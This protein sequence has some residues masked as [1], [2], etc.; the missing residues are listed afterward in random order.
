MSRS[1]SFMLPIEIDSDGFPVR[2]RIDEMGLFCGG[3]ISDLGKEEFDRLS[4]LFLSTGDRAFTFYVYDNDLV[5]FGKFSAGK[6]SVHTHCDHYSIFNLIFEDAA[7]GNY[8]FVSNNGQW[9]VFFGKES[10]VVNCMSIIDSPV[11]VEAES[12]FESSFYSDS[13]KAEG[14]RFIEKY[15]NA[16]LGSPPSSP[17]SGSGLVL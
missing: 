11:L 13:E 16:S 14:I 9:F 10:F 2:E 5:N 6:E 17:S 3:I 15:N 7:V 12:V 1:T 4:D 8:L